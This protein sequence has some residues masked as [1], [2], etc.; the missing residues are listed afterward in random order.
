LPTPAFPTLSV[1]FLKKFEAV[2]LA[3]RRTLTIDD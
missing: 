2:E 1:P 3:E